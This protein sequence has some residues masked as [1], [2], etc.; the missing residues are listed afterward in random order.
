[1]ETSFTRMSSRGQVVIPQGIREE[2]GLKEGMPLAVTSYRGTVVL[3]ALETAD[4]VKEWERLF[5]WGREHARK[6]NI[7][8][9]DVDAAIAKARGK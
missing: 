5:A 6:H 9:E 7:K 3:K 1:M 4:L 8:P 2:L